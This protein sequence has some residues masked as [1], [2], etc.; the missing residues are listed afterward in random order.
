MVRVKL[1]GDSTGNYFHTMQG[2]NYLLITTFSKIFKEHDEPE[3][4]RG[5]YIIKN[6]LSLFVIYIN[7]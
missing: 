7:K 3:I 1:K 4:V 5:N 2:D 6:V